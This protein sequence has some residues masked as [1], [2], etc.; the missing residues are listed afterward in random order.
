MRTVEMRAGRATKLQVETAA[1]D[2]LTGNEGE[3]ANAGA[4]LGEVEAGKR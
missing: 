2:L 3:T 4:M 1:I